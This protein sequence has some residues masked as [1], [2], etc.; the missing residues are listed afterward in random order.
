MTSNRK[1]SDL[2]AGKW[3]RAPDLNPLARL[4]TTKLQK[5]KRE[6][7]RDADPAR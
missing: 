5:H 7:D 1:A 4:L 2:F 6:G 3:L